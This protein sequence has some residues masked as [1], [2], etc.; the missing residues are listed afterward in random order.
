MEGQAQD[1]AYKDSRTFA[2]GSLSS[3]GRGFALSQSLCQLPGSTMDTRQS[4]EETTNEYNSVKVL[5]GNQTA[6]WPHESPRALG[7]GQSLNS[8]QKDYFLK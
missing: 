8:S 2:L 1:P 3:R 4:R 7:K 5:H 6:K